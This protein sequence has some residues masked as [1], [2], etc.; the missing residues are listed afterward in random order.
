MT[1]RQRRAP[2]QCPITPDGTK[3]CK[4]GCGQAVPK[5]RLSWASQACVDR[6]MIANHSQHARRAVFARDRGVC[7]VCGRN[8]ER[9]WRRRKA[10]ERY[11]VLRR[12][13]PTDRYPRRVWRDGWSEKWNRLRSH[14][15]ASWPRRQQMAQ[16]GIAQRIERLK[17]DGW[18]LH[19]RTS[20][21]EAD[22][23]VPVVEGGGQTGLENL[24]TLCWP[25][26]R[27]ATAELAA[28]RAARRRQE[29]DAKTGQG[30]LL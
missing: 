4:C 29:A 16:R 5:G 11:A 14:W 1:L 23:I 28:R 25:C 26:H 9:A 12:L 3:L 6:W 24:R 8:A 13:D 19:I 10:A 27:K 17:A 2:R 18:P 20:W 30:V 15:L 21:W 22:H 7:A